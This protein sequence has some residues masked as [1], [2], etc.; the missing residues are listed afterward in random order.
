MRLNGII[1]FGFVCALLLLASPNLVQA[2]AGAIAGT[3]TYRERIAL[4]SNA[5][6]TVQVA[7][8]PENGAPQV[9]AEQRFN[10]NGAQPPF[11]YTVNY[12][13]ARINNDARYTVQ[14]NISVDG[15]ARF[16]TGQVFPV[17]TR[18]AGVNDVNITLASVAGQ[19]QN[20]PPTSNGTILLL[21]AGLALSVAALSYVLRKRY[22]GA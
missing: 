8:L 9:I 10:T 21:V 1:M 19:G 18:G 16:A 3:L 4:P 14:A 15:Q 7:E 6:V 13:P 20:L 11:R 22:G 2:Q 5:I 17:I 12:D